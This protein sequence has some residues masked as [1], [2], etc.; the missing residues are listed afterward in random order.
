[1]NEA[2]EMSKRFSTCAKNK[3]DPPPQTPGTEGTHK[4]KSE[5]IPLI[6]SSSEV[7]QHV[8]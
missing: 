3:M 6:A 8:Q 2:A 7:V 5:L 1:M 4:E